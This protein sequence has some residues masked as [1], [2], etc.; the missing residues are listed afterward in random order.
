MGLTEGKHCERCSDTYTD[1]ETDKLGHDY[2]PVVTAPTCE[3]AGYTT[4]TCTRGDHTY[5]ADHVEALGHEE[6][7]DAAIDATCTETGLT[8][9]KHCERCNKVLVEQRIKD[10]LGHKESEMWYQSETQHWKECHCSER[11][12]LENHYDTDLDN[13]CDQCDFKLLFE[14][15][16]TP[17]IELS[18]DSIWGYEIDF[19]NKVIDLDVIATG[20]L[21]QNILE[22]KMIRF[23]VTEG[24]VT[25]IKF[26]DETTRIKNGDTI[27]IYTALS[28]NVAEDEW[29]QETYTIRILGDVNCNGR[30]D[31]N[32]YLM[33]K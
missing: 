9:G 4:Y 33:M 17:V 26:N 30:I 31:S 23:E 5:V 27:T 6:V 15:E 18:E 8:E 28:N 32:D 20:L 2:T 14:T 7:I 13:H 25:K 11:L 21:K 19:E 16:M 12:N 29:T 22:G 1:A 3:D 24:I 10:S